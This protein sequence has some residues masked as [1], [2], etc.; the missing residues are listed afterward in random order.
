MAL[1]GR[2]GGCLDRRQARAAGDRQ[3]RIQRKIEDAQR[4]ADAER[5]TEAIEILQGLVAAHPGRRDLVEKLLEITHGFERSIYV[6]NF[7]KDDIPVVTIG[8]DARSRVNIYPTEAFLLSRIDGRLKVRDILRITPVSE[9]EGL[10][11]LKR[12]LSAKV[13]DF[14]YRKVTAEAPSPK[15]RA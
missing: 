4:A 12:L 3:D 2:G 7:T 8:P 15:V 10:R 11:A 14:P 9:F 1:Q 13:I 6:H 5:W